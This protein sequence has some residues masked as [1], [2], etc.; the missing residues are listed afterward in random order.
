MF[1]VLP[2]GASMINPAS[3]AFGMQ[4]PLGFQTG[5][6]GIPSVD[7]SQQIGG[8]QPNFNALGVGGGSGANGGLD[9][10]GK[11]D[12]AISGISTLAGLWNAFQ[13]RKL[14]K[15]QFEFTKEFST[16]NLQNSIQ[17]YN[18]SLSDRARSRGHTEGQSQQQVD[19]YIT[20]NSLKNFGG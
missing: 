10:W 20:A 5:A 16:A 18:T 7:T 2:A 1:N 9:L 6:I 3:L 8:Y 13:A 11:A 4:Q 17:A 14:A 15:K 19:G 12:V